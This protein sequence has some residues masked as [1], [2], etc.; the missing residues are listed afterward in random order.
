MT[1]FQHSVDFQRSPLCGHESGMGLN[2][3]RLACHS[4]VELLQ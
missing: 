2:E 4:G 3:L 1:S